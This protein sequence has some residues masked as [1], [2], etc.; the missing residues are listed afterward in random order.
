MHEVSIAKSIVD[1]LQEEYGSN[2]L[3]SIL[4]VHVK[5]GV[6]S[7]IENQLLENAYSLVIEGTPLAA[8]ALKTELVPVMA[9]CEPCNNIFPVEN[10][11]FL[12]PACGTPTHD[13]R[14]GNELTIFKIIM[15]ESI[16]EETNE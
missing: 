12:C 1:T 6:L 5:I 13:V 16:Y 8:S 9:H 3:E 11:Q 2:Q 4:E 14:E 7:G 10:Y 15:Q